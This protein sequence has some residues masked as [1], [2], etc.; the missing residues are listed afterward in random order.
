MKAELHV[1]AD[2]ILK[3]GV[4][5]RHVIGEGVGIVHQNIDAAPIGNRCGHTLLGMLAIAGERFEGERLAAVG[6]DLARHIF[7]LAHGAAGDDHLRAFFCIRNGDGFADALSG[8]GDDCD[9][10]FEPPT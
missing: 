8:P 4:F 3:P 2:V 7:E 10:A 9:A 6:L 1:D 5:N